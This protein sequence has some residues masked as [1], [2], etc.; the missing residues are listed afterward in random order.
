MTN[1]YE[2]PDE[3]DAEP[4]TCPILE[5]GAIVTDC[6]LIDART[7]EEL[8]ARHAKAETNE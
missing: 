3:P 4:K 1:P 7:V 6:E 8:H 2:Y 5:C